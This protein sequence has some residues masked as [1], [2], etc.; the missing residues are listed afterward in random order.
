MIFAC[1]LSH[2]S[3]IQFLVTLW[4]VAFQDPLSLGFSRQEYW[5]GLQFPSSGDLPNPGI[6]PQSLTSPALT[7][8]FFTT[9]TCWEAYSFFSSMLLLLPLSVHVFAIGSRFVVTMKLKY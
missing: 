3:H 5:S 7:G 1:M 2:F 8:K 6:K 4:A 9:S